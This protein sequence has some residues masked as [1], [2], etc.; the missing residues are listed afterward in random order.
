MAAE[1]TETTQEIIQDYLELDERD[2]GFHLLAFYRFSTENFTYFHQYYLNHYVSIFL[3]LRSL[4]LSDIFA[5]LIRIL[6]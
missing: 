1:E 5:S 3:F 2:P 6:A 4:Y